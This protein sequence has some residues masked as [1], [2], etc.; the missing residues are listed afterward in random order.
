MTRVHPEN[1]IR[2]LYVRTL[3]FR[4]TIPDLVLEFRWLGTVPPVHQKPPTA[5]VPPDWGR[6]FLTTVLSARSKHPECTNVRSA[7]PSHQVGQGKTGPRPGHAQS[8]VWPN[9]TNKRSEFLFPHGGVITRRDR[10]DAWAS[11][12]WGRR[13]R[14]NP[15]QGALAV[16]QKEDGA[17]RSGGSARRRIPRT[18]RKSVEGNVGSAPPLPRVTHYYSGPPE[19]TRRRPV[20]PTFPSLRPRS[21]AKGRSGGR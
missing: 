4:T 6:S 9:N 17:N 11:S 8:A 18:Q 2:T 21:L 16:E 3:C 14:G 1:E 12:C 20:R 7:A 19:R 13:S 10:L 15:L 5:P